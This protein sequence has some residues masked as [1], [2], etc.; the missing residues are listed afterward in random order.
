MIN[1]GNIYILTLLKISQLLKEDNIMNFCAEQSRNNLLCFLEDVEYFNRKEV[2]F[3]LEKIFREKGVKWAVG[4]SMDL[5]LRGLTDEFHD[6]DLIVDKDSVPVIKEIMEELGAELMATGGNGF[7]ESDVYLHYH[8]G[9][10]DIDIISGFRVM[11]FNTQYHYCYKDDEIDWMEIEETKVP[12][13]ALEAMYILYFMMEG[14]QPKR[15]F[16][17]RLIEQF[18]ETNKPE[19]Q[20]IFLKAME[21][22]LP[23]WIKWEIKKLL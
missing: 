22:N 4:C 5:F 18:F 20:S 2:F 19:H 15:R 17:R 6:L 21:F 7:C 16:K 23:G 9:R 13:I 14:W 12:L 8:L 11:T 1:Y 3:Q 10:V